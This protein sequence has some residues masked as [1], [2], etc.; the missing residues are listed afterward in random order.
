[1]IKHFIKNYC[2]S[3]GSMDIFVEPF[4]PKPELIVYGNTP[5]ANELIKF[6]EKFS[7]NF[8]QFKDL[9]ENKN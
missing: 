2:P 8:V 6:A 1:M 3:E 9:E 4:Y 5:I 7:F